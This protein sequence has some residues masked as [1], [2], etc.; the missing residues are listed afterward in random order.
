M[1]TSTSKI[2]TASAGSGK[3]HTLT[4][5]LIELLLDKVKSENIIAQTFTKKAAGEI[6]ARVI[7]RL[8]GLSS[9]PPFD[10]S[11]KRTLPDG[12]ALK[13]LRDLI[14]KQDRLR[15]ETLDS[16]FADLCKSHFIELSLMPNWQI[17]DEKQVEKNTIDALKASI[18]KIGPD[19]F[20]L[21]LDFL[22]SNK[23]PNRVLEP[24]L[25]EL[26]D[27]KS[28]LTFS[29]RNVWGNLPLVKATHS[30]EQVEV[31]LKQLLEQS[32]Q[33][34]F[35]KGVWKSIR[36]ILKAVEEKNYTYL[37]KSEFIGKI[38]DGNLSYYNKTLPD[39]IVSSVVALSGAVQNEVIQQTNSR[40]LSLLGILTAYQTEYQQLIKDTGK[41]SFDDIA[42]LTNSKVTELESSDMFSRLS[43]SLE[44]LLLDEFQ[45]TSPIQWN[46][47]ENISKHI[48]ESSSAENSLFIVGDA[49]QAIY[50]WRGGSAEVFNHLRTIAPHIPEESLDTN[51]RSHPG[52]IEF[53]NTVFSGLSENEHLLRF[54]ESIDSWLEEFKPHIANKKNNEHIV[55]AS[56]YPEI[57]EDYHKYEHVIND[58]MGVQS[59][60]PNASIAVLLRTNSQLEEF[61]HYLKICGLEFT[62]SQTSKLDSYYPIQ[63][64]ISLV[65]LAEHPKDQL[66]LV[67]LLESNLDLEQLIGSDTKEPGI[68]SKLIKEKFLKEG[69]AITL[70]H[71]ISKYLRTCSSESERNII[72]IAISIA[73][74][75]ERKGLTN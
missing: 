41:L 14:A 7:T 49:K 11:I 63:L 52:V 33:I 46:I 42:E 27:F 6:Y 30:I 29:D 1:N 69:F 28:I 26:R 24:I 8:I 2:V 65:T 56:A 72:Y 32:E 45:D 38:L 75:F 53:V 3:T 50:S 51:Y 13:T 58:I 19:T 37:C 36:S 47:L 34:D 4:T 74:E 54:K 66:S 73:L 68:I 48:L 18:A 61:C 64:L 67:H 23:T 9:T 60:E 31:E 40:T 44:H 10:P 57:P 62:S 17:A 16:F 25:R 15:I 43:M 59:T 39:A 22:F 55:H 35:H 21:L 70:S 71:F 20:R 12:L 5:K